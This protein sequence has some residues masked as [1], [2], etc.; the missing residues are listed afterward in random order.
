MRAARTRGVG[1]SYERGT[2]VG[3]LHSRTGGRAAKSISLKYEPA[4][5]PLQSS[6]LALAYRRS[7]SKV[8]EP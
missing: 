3:E 2:P 5:E 1:V 6:L 8:Y 7:G 4:S